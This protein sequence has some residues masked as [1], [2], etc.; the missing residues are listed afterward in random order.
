VTSVR[1]V[2]GPY[3]VLVQSYRWDGAVRQKQIYLGARIPADL[4]PLVW[5]LN[6]RIWNETRYPEFDKIR[7]AFQSRAAALPPEVVASEREDFLIRFTFS[8]NRIEGSSLT[9]EETRSVIE[10]SEVPKAKPLHDVLESKRHAEL[11]RKLMLG[12]EPIDL[13]HL[14]GWHRQL[15]G[16]TKPLLAGK[17]RD[18]PDRIG[19]SAHIP[20]SPVEVRP[21][22]V[23]LLRWTSISKVKMHP[24]ELAG[25]F[26]QR[27]ESIH[28]F[29]DGN[30]RVGRLAMNLLLA[31]AGYP[32]MD[33]HFGRRYAYY[34]ALEKSDSAKSARPFLAWFYLRYAREQAYLLQSSKS[35]R[36]NTKGQTEEDHP[37]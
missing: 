32:M 18:Y 17:I 36:S 15:F 24:V 29:G 7:S 26:H 25:T 13:A 3:K 37:R 28:P 20:P 34:R 27:F 8:T 2:A 16:E 19:E 22:L 10:N 14:L 23:E 30:G 12:P 6:R 31:A 5:E 35:D 1:V 21:M 11:V 9:L 4:E 33:I